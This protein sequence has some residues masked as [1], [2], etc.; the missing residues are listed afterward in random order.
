MAGFG[1]SRRHVAQPIRISRQLV[2]GGTDEAFVSGSL[3]WGVG[4]IGSPCVVGNLDWAVLVTQGA[5]GRVLVVREVT[6][7]QQGQ[8]TQGQKVLRH[9]ALEDRPVRT[10]CWWGSLR[11]WGVTTCRVRGDSTQGPEQD[12]RSLPAQAG[13]QAG[14]LPVPQG[15]P[16]SELAGDRPGWKGEV[17]GN[18]NTGIGGHPGV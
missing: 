16:P 9:R 5:V 12:K 1:R 2:P 3:S 17:G 11:G 13:S 15:W 4:T 8:A 18:Q 6:R 14:P 7:G 10:R